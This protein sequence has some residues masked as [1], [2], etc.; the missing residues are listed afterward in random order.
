MWAHYAENHRGLCLCFDVSKADYFHAV[1]YLPRR[2]QLDDLGRK[3]VEDINTSDIVRLMY[4][5]FD[6]WSYE[7]EFRTHTALEPEY[8]DQNSRHYFHPFD[9][10]LRLVKLLVGH[11]S[12]VTRQQVSDALGPLISEVESFKVRPAFKDFSLTRNLRKREW[13]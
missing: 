9:E 7:Q 10:N 6:G 4:S 8:F 11:Q 5:K 1:T 3:K 2:L 12:E 13:R